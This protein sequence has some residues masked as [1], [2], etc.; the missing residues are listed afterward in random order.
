MLGLWVFFLFFATQLKIDQD[1]NKA[2]PKDAKLAEYQN[3]FKK[4]PLASKIVFAVGN[5]N[6]Y[7]SDSVKSGIKELGVLL[8]GITDSLVKEVVWQFSADQQLNSF[9][10]FYDYLPHY[11]P[12]DQQKKFFDQ[13]DSTYVN[14]AIE[15][16]I[17][18]LQSPEGYAL[19]DWILRDPAGLM[20]QVLKPIGALSEAAE[21][22]WEENRLYTKDNSHGIL[23][24]DLA[25]STADT[26]KSAQLV[27]EIEKTI[28][29][30]GDKHSGLRVHVFGGALMAHKNGEVIKSDTRLTLSLAGLGILVLLLWYYK[31]WSMPIWFVLPSVF[32]F[33]FSLGIIYLLKGDISILSI[34]AGSIVMGI[35][36]DYAFHFFTHFKHSKSVSKTKEGISH[37]LAI[38]CLT[39]VLAFLSLLFLKSEVLT[40]FGLFAALSL[41]GALLFVLFGLP[42]LL[43]IFKVTFKTNELDNNNPRALPA[44]LSK[45]RIVFTLASITIVMAFFA[46]SVQF[47]NDLRKINYED[48]FLTKAEKVI[49]ASDGQNKTVYLVSKGNTFNEALKNV[50]ALSFRLSRYVQKDQINDFVS[51]SNIFVTKDEAATRAAYWKQRAQEKHLNWSHLFDKEGESFGFK[52]GSFSSFVNLLENEPKAYEAPDSMLLFTGSFKNFISQSSQGF[53]LIS[54]V[55]L[56]ADSVFAVQELL[57]DL[58][59]L[60]VD[61]SLMANSLME[62]VSDNFNLLLA[63][64]SGLVFLVL[65]INY[66]RIELALLTFL[67]MVI[68]WIWILGICS[69]FDIKFN[70]VNVMVTTFVF[71]LGDDFCIFMSDGLLSKYKWGKNKIRSYQSAII[72]SVTT[73]VIGTGVL[74]FAKHPALQ[75]IALLS[76][77]GMVC[78]A[79]V[80]ILLQPIMFHFAVT[81]RAHKKIAPLSLYV[82]VASTIA[83]G[84]F[85]LGSIILTTLLP[86]FWLFP[87]PRRSKRPLIVWILSRFAKTVVYLMPN[88]RK[89]IVNPN[90]ETFKE[91]AVIIANH[92]SFVDILALLMLHPK[93]IILTNEWVWNSPLFGWLVRYAGFPTSVK[94]VEENMVLMQEAVADGFS[95][96]IF[97][98]GTRSV[99]GKIARFHKGAFLAAEKLKLNI[100]PVILH[101]FNDTIKKND[102]T[103]QSGHTTIKILDR[104]KA[105]DEE[106]G[107]NYSERTKLISK[108]FKANFNELRDKK[109]CAAYFKK[110]LIASYIY[111][112][113]VLEWYLKIKLRL[114]NNFETFHEHCPK[115]GL[116]YDLGCGY[117]YLTLMLHLTGS[118]RQ[119]VAWDYDLKKIQVAQNNYLK[120]DN[121]LFAQEDLNV[122]LPKAASTYII[123]DTLHYLPSK[124]QEEVLHH[125]MKMALPSGRILLRDGFINTNQHHVTERTERWSTKML[126]FNKS[127]HQLTFLSLD[128]LQQIAN[129]NNWKLKRLD[130]NRASS[131]QTYLLEQK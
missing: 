91:P 17:R 4:S 101:G 129:E 81:K 80:S 59:V 36:L 100:L 10:Y 93:I 115:G 121:T 104:V 68:S 20:G 127:E 31:K 6:E 32:G 109:E 8:E 75:S 9:Q 29:H 70:F 74:I 25:F 111:K 65:L 12:V 86:L 57:A 28:S 60:L 39:T 5:S 40:D 105:T 11:L 131:N 87:A 107:T 24:L 98:E 69:I 44:V 7:P 62:V 126:K 47:E 55:N 94:N 2:F 71:G 21:F 53:E 106:F 108:Y 95:V 99:S 61:K 50:N 30:F 110:R 76:V 64:S 63:L 66:G 123:K 37:A 124:R 90:K 33:S 82:L 51:L 56:P 85:A 27:Q 89:Q 15:R 1:V 22:N 96:A 3:F 97:P 77:I 46:P 128:K 45:K 42:P 118:Q 52:N 119:L 48:E 103:L 83:F 58:P 113:P 92:Q 122:S 18:S 26:E 116:I 38:S 120:G 19:K 13:L 84:Y 114:E 49:T 16:G 73:T 14:Q 67:P 34:G 79:L 35:M 72:L 78:I 23:F 117:G 102:Y 54:I 41:I 88:V 125:C 112:G 43:T 130:S